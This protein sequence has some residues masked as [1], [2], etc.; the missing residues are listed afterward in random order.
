MSTRSEIADA[1]ATAVPEARVIGYAKSIDNMPVGQPVIMLYRESVVPSPH[2]GLRTEALSVWVAVN[3]TDPEKAD[4][5]LDPFLDRVLE[6]L[7]GRAFKA[8]TWT[9]AD[10]EALADAWPAYKVQTTIQTQRSEL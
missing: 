4:D 7:D 8:L 2:Q 1:L 6:V 10:R 3:V 9:T 5:V